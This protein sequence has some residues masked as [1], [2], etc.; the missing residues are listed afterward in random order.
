MHACT[1]SLLNT[2]KEKKSK[3]V[4]LHG[5]QLIETF[6]TSGIQYNEVAFISSRNWML[7]LHIFKDK[8]RETVWISYKKLENTLQRQ[9][10]MILTKFI[11]MCVEK[12]RKNQTFRG[13]KFSLFLS[14]L[15]Q[16][17]KAR[18]RYT[19]FFIR[20]FFYRNLQ[21]EIWQNIKNMLRTYPK[22]NFIF[23]AFTFLSPENL[24]YIMSFMES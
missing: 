3:K 24:N 19:L 7:F 6:Q 4:R 2:R 1:S 23:K 22:N 20:T 9:S 15:K 17:K 10:S 5:M 16:L 12:A 11:K 14:G 18:R 8:R 13:F 21:P